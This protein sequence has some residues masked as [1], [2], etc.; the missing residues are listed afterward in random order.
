MRATGT[1]AS[2]ALNCISDWGNFLLHSRSRWISAGVTGT[3]RFIARPSTSNQ[4]CIPSCSG[5][6]SY[7]RTNFMT[8]KEMSPADRLA[9]LRRFAI[10]ITVLNIL[11]H[12]VFGFEQA[13]I[14]PFVGIGSAYACELVL[15]LI[16]CYMQK[17][18]PR[19][20]GGWRKVV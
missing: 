15:E 11:G 20:V 7:G 4:A 16:D 19:F 13:W 14:Q 1:P 10:A 5:L 2:A 17:R 9:G 8:M 6:K 18:K 3:E 12:T